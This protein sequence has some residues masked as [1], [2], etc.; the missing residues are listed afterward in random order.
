MSGY[1]SQIKWLQNTVVL[2]DPQW[3]EKNISITAKL[4]KVTISADE[5][6]L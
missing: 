6:L 2:L 4:D 5:G 1:T 3:S